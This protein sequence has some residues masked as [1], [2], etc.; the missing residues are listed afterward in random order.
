[1]DAQTARFV[2]KMGRYFEADG[3]PRIGGRLY[4][5]LILQDQ[6]RAL[7]DLAGALAVSK[8]SISTNARLLEQWGLI[9]RVTQPGDRR[10]FYEVAPSSTRQLELRLARIRQLT[11]LLGEGCSVPA[12]EK[13]AVRRR[14]QAM[15]ESTSEIAEQMGGILERWR[16]GN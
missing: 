3:I 4:G 6:P 5:Y 7:E 1:M 15:R 12:A 8:T 14:L 9:E 2:E 10:D 13:P 16:R 11:E